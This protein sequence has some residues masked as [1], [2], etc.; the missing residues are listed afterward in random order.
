MKEA[1]TVTLYRDEHQLELKRSIEAGKQSMIRSSH[2]G[3]SEEDD[4]YESQMFKNKILND[5][6]PLRSQFLVKVA[7]GKELSHAKLGKRKQK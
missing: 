5:K 4:V 2:F 7:E 6:T 3:S 1:T